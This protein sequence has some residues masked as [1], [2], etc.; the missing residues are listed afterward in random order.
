[1]NKF[2]LTG[3]TVGGQPLNLLA[4]QAAEG[5]RIPLAEGRKLLAAKAL[6]S[7][8]QSAICDYLAA[9]RI[10]YSITNAEESFNRRGQRVQRIAPGWPDVTACFASYLL[11]IECKRAVGGV[12]SFEQADCLNRLHQAGALVVVARSVDDVISLLATKRTSAA[13]VAEIIAALKKGPKL[14]RSR[15]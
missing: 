6:E 3:T 9:Q 15:R 12:L 11:A 4:Q 5:A 2:A 8:V 14:K 10:P 13:T 7:S 1:M